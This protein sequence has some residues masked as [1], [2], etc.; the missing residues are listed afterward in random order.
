M[1]VEIKFECTQCGKCCHGPANAGP[2]LSDIDAT[3]LMRGIGPT[4]YR[5]GVKNHGDG[6]P[7]IRMRDGHCTFLDGKKCSV[8][9][10]RPDQCRSF[11]FWP[12]LWNEPGKYKLANCEGLS[13]VE[14]AKGEQCNQT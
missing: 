3:R 10:V 12:G 14:T 8:Y 2:R 5:L 7:Q 6:V 4:A 1:G 13:V 9:D 11:P